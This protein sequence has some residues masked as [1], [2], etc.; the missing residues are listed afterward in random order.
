MRASVHSS[1]AG[2]TVSAGF[3][4]PPHQLGLGVDVQPGEHERHRVAEA[5]DAVQRH[6][7]RRRRRLAPYAVDAHAVGAVGGQLDA[8]D[9]Q[10]HIGIGVARAGDLVEQLGG[11]GVDADRPPVPGMLGDHRR[12]VGVDLGEREARHSVRSGD[13]GEERVVAAGGL[14][15]AL[16]DVA[17]GDR[18][19]ELVVVV[20]AP[21]E[22]G[23][24]GPTITDASVTRPVTTTSA[25]LSRQSTMP[26]APR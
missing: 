4:L 23:G 18:T 19:G 2:L 20:A 3:Q 16:D 7:Q 10:R 21:A 15:P 26:H 13:L 24:G 8:V 1:S 17:R 9:P 12:P 5:A 6:L 14:H 11:D 22:V 25:P